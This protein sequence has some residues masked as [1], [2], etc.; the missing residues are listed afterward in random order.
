[1]EFGSEIRRR[2]LTG[3]MSK[4]E[5]CQ[6]SEIHGK[7]PV[8]I[9]THEEP[10]GYRRTHPQQRTIEP[11]RPVIRQILDADAPAPRK[12]RHTA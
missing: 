8:K 5:A 7:T 11:M 4:R 2:V 6:E 12:Q 3:E 9:L 1:M 10:P